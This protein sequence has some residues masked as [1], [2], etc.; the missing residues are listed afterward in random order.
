LHSFLKYLKNIKYPVK[1]QKQKELW[2]I[3]G[4]IK[5]KSNQSFKFDIRPLK[6]IK[7]QIGKEGSFKSKADKIVF[8][9]INSWIIIDTEELHDFLKQKQQ[10]I[11]C[12]DELI[13][14]LDWNIILPK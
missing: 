12:V 11:V 13:S 1:E 2:D 5:N 6:K 7:D 9:S 14:K 8:E 4:I 10:K 3:E